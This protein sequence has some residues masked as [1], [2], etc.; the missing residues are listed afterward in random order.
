MGAKWIDDRRDVQAALQMMRR[1]ELTGREWLTSMRGH[2]AHA[3]LSLTDPAPFLVDLGQSARR[4]LL[5]TVRRLGGGR[6]AAAPPPDLEPSGGS[7]RL[8]GTT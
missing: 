3:V 2:R 7:E 5:G 8:G 6:R 1:Q 4:A